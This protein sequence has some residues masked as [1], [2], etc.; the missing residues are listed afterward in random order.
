MDDG[1][2]QGDGT[3]RHRPTIADL[4]EA[5]GVSVATVDRVLNRRHPVREATALRVLEAAESLGY[6]ATSLLRSRLQ[7]QT[8][9]CR[10]GFL[11]QR[12]SSPFYRQLA[13]HLE[14]AVLGLAGPESRPVVEFVDELD[15]ATIVLRMRA[16]GRRVD[17]LAVVS[18]DHPRVTEE[19]DRLRSQGIPTFTLLSDLSA[20]M[21]AGYIGLDARK[22]GR[23][24][25][26]AITRLARRPGAVA[27]F[28]GSHRY[29]DH[30]TREISLRSYL[31]EHA[32]DFALLEPLVDLEQPSVAYDAALPLLR[33]HPE[34]AGI[35]SAGAGTEGIIQALL[36]EGRATDV[37]LVC[38]ELTP[39]VRSALIDGVVDL[40]IAT[41]TATLA[42]RAVRGL[43]DAIR[44]P[45]SITAGQILLPFE[46]YGPENV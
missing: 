6:H 1:F 14:A 45:S 17:G 2:S 3:A 42:E 18:V 40:A 24:A 26:W 16:L 21:R 30:D 11:L 32:P 41:P 34:L 20:P 44:Q 39:A 25:A 27:I 5:A 10:L 46:L 13:G 8:T 33:R 12:E 38:N 7:G 43:L 28:V 37:I 31:R 15:A 23:T 9:P 4:A 29:L 35:Y 22:A 19:I 36:E